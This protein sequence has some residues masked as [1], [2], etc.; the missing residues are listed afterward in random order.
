MAKKKII[1]ESFNNTDIWLVTFN[2]LM[3]LLLTFFV[4]FLSMCTLDTN[5]ILGIKKEFTETMGVVEPG[6]IEE[7][8]AEESTAVISGF[9]RLFN[10]YDNNRIQSLHIPQVQNTFTDTD[11]LLNELLHTIK[12]DDAYKINE[13]INKGKSENSGSKIGKDYYKPGVS[14]VHNDRGV[15]L[16]LPSVLLFKKGSSE[17]EKKAYPLLDKIAGVMQKTDNMI[18][19]EGHTDNLPI[20]TEKYLSNVELSIYRSLR[21]AG[22][23]IN[24]MNISPER[25]G[26]AGYGD[27]RFIAENKTTAERARN[28]RVEIVFIKNN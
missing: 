15:V 16:Q 18:Y 2:D 6:K 24:N 20:L 1:I 7:K 3:T 21:V 12:Q 8:G 23:F 19:I 4:L 14:I 5:A 25:I 11:I 28:R 9:S 26:I 13:N 22:Y 27:S 10:A 17:L